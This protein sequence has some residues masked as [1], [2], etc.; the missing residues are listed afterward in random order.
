M[1][2]HPPSLG[3]F[4]WALCAAAL[5]VGVGVGAAVSLSHRSH[6]AAASSASTSPVSTWAPGARPAPSFALTDQNGKAVSLAGFR[7]RPLIVTFID[8][9]CRNFCPREASVLSAAVKSFGAERPG[10]VAVSVNPWANS[11]QNFREDA[12]HWRLAPQWQW[13]VG[14]RA[15]LA[16]VWKDYAVGVEVTTKTIAGVT[17][18]EITHTGAAYLIDGSG[19]ER[20]LLLYPFRT[21]DV[22]G[23]MRTMLSAD[24]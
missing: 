22:V 9:L 10:V 21:A 23:A 11:R 17:V 12:T 14:S 16:S 18:H 6:A 2:A 24:G 1:S 13:G 7:G 20:A 3:R 5:A 19:H 8:P 4:K 15:Q